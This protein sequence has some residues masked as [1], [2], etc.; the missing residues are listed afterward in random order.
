MGSSDSDG[1]IPIELEEVKSLADKAS[2]D[3]ISRLEKKLA[4]IKTARMNNNASSTDSD[5]GAAKMQR[6]ESDEELR[7]FASQLPCPQ[8]VVDMA[9]S[10]GVSGNL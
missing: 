3:E 4:R 9:V 1:F 10:S 7:Q 2:D 8:G 6:S 5:Q